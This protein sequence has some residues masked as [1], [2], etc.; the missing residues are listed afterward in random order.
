MNATASTETLKNA[1]VDSLTKNL[2]WSLIGHVFL[3]LIVL[4]KSVVFSGKKIPY[5]PTLKVD[6]VALPDSLKKDITHPSNSQSNSQF[7]KDISKLLKQVENE[8]RKT[9]EAAKPS[10]SKNK[11]LPPAE[12]NEMTTKSSHDDSAS[13]SVVQRNKRALD[14][15]KS[16]S[17]IHSED[18]P[19]SKPGLPIK[20]NQLSPGSSISGDAKEALVASYYDHLR[21]RLQENWTLPPW[22]SRQNLAAQVQIYIDQQG[23]LHHIKFVKTSGNTQFD[24]AVKKAVQE[25]QPF[26]NPP[27][28][29][30]SSLVSD[31]ILVGFP[32]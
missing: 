24:E 13:K 20:G 3:F 28:E 29:L 9:E 21:D 12:K 17:K 2:K 16:L 7:N 22:I 15:L 4:I 27:E 8:A 1:P 10:R 25:S 14:R 26:P 18:L 32:L 6:L 23:R 30:A 5:V 31:G 11:P 19:H